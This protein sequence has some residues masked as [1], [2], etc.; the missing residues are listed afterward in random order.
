MD[1]VDGVL[2]HPLPVLL[3]GIGGGAFASATGAKAW[4]GGANRVE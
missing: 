4:I 1:E 2:I 3:C